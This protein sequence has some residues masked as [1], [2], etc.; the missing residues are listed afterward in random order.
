MIKMKILI[1]KTEELITIS[2]DGKKLLINKDNK[3]F[4]KLIILSKEEIKELYQKDKFNSL[5]D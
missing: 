4:N 1:S 3:L 5:L 2:L